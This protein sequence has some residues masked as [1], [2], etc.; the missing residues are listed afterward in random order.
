[1]TRDKENNRYL[2]SKWIHKVYIFLEKYDL[3]NKFF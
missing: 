2:K 3:F 1:M